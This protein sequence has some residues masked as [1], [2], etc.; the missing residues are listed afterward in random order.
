MGEKPPERPKPLKVGLYC[1]DVIVTSTKDKVD[2]KKWIGGG[3]DVNE[4]HKT[5]LVNSC[6]GLDMSKQ[7]RIIYEYKIM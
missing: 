1:L 6:L 4:C 3:P 5:S 2:I 7:S